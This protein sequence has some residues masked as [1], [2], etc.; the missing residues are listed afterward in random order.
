MS[1]PRILKWISGGAE[2]L[3]AI[4]VLGGSI[5]IGFLYIP[6]LVTLALHIVTLVLTKKEGGNTVG[7]ILGI[8]TSCV[9]WIPFVGWAMHTVTAILLMIDASKPEVQRT[10]P[11]IIDQ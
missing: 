10:Q 8:V 5:V 7:S 6:L 3:L 1:T 2:A 11:D 9:A 4:P